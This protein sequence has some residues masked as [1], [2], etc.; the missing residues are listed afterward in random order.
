MRATYLSHRAQ[1][2][3]MNT[4]YSKKLIYSAKGISNDVLCLLIIYL[5][6]II[7]IVFV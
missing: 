3:I 5:I 2:T 1:T 4:N 6:S 7:F